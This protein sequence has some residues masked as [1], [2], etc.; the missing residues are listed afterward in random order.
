MS[1]MDLNP[2]KSPLAE[3]ERPR[4]WRFISAANFAKTILES[5]QEN[6]H[7]EHEFG[8]VDPGAFRHLSG[9]FYRRTQSELEAL[10]FVLVGDVEDATL[11]ATS[12]DLRTFMRTMVD[13]S[14]TTVA[15]F[16]HIKPRFL[17]RI[18]MFL[19]R[20]PSKYIE[21]ESYTTAGNTFCT[22]TAPE[23]VPVPHPDGIRKDCVARNPRVADLYGRHL[24]TLSIYRESC[25]FKRIHGIDD[26]ILAQN[27]QNRK[28]Y[29]HMQKI[30][31]ATSEYLI[32]QGVPE[33]M[34]DEVYDEIQ[35]LLAMARPNS[36]DNDSVARL[37]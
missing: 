25:Q 22:T 18:G 10:G 35:R 12:S 13:S 11:K 28:I 5:L 33:A 34:V 4:P 20:L 29:D 16:Y 26:V 15:A 19:L 7:P 8:I 27:L 24:R 6:V 30:G 3:T 17:L 14:G 31:W 37:Q 1:T 23:S 32:N 2:Y 36:G 9:R 21:F